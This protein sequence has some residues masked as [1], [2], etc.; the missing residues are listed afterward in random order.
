MQKTH[1]LKLALVSSTL[2]FLSGCGVTSYIRDNF[3]GNAQVYY[4]TNDFKSDPSKSG[5]KGTMK[6]YTINGKT[7]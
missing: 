6:P 5:S 3:N 4:P 2:L 1:M 7:Y